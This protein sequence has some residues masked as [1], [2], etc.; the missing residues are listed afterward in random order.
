MK[1]KYNW[2]EIKNYDEIIF[3]FYN[4]IAKISINRPKNTMLLHP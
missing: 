2:K 4:G 1:S 3:S